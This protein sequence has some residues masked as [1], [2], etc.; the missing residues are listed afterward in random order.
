M[1]CKKCGADISRDA[2]YCPVCGEKQGSTEKRNNESIFEKYG[3]QAKEIHCESSYKLD[4]GYDSRARKAFAIIGLVL[5]IL[6]LLF[7]VAL[8]S[9]VFLGIPAL[10]FSIL[11][12]KSYK[13]GSAMTG[14]V[15]TLIGIAINLILV[16]IYYVR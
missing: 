1:I 4:A 2:A 16:I 8:F 7:C 3:S 13:R 14:L 10:I 6:T 15:L 12:I 5:G 11:G 9:F